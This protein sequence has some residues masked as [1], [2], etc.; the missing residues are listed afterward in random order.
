MSRRD[1][2]D[3]AALAALLR[4]AK[5][6]AVVGASPNVTRPVHGVMAYMIAAGYRVIPV[7]PGHGGREILGQRVYARLA[8]VPEAIDIVDIFRRRE[9]L[10][11]VVDE[12][13][14]LE[15]KPKAIWMQLDLWDD[16][17]AEKARAAGVTVVMDRCIK[18]EH[19]RLL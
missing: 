8:D 17:A 5:T 19:A 2:L 18:I 6:I 3:D 14:A 16:P 10:A 15:P 9:A 12:A 1:G 13:L 11:G 4:S 7:N